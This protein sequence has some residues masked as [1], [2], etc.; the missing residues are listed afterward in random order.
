M[1]K[2]YA[3]LEER[4]YDQVPTGSNYAGQTQNFQKTV[5]HCTEVIGPDRLFGFMQ[6]TWHPT[7]EAFRDIHMNAI[8][9]VEKAREWY[10]ANGR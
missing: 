3:Q 4:G 2:A 10:D 6:S 5:Q 1:V 7:Q 9:Q 8:E